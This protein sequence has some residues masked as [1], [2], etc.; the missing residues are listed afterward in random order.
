MSPLRPGHVAGELPG[1]GRAGLSR[2]TPRCVTCKICGDGGH[3]AASTVP[4]AIAARRARRRA[5]RCPASIS[6]SSANSGGKLIGGRGR[7]GPERR[8]EERASATRGERPIDPAK[9][10]RGSLADHIDDARLRAVAESHGD[11]ESAQAGC[12][13][14]GRRA[15]AG[16]G[17]SRLSTCAAIGARGGGDGCRAGR[18]ATPYGV[19]DGDQERAGPPR[20]NAL[21]GGMGMGMG[22]GK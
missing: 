18:R 3:P 2:V 10:S 11:I 17:L 13:T 7:R 12:D 6:P 4:C 19:V 21:S 20:V 16:S 14:R 5:R 9:L 15:D 22:M 8:R 1:E